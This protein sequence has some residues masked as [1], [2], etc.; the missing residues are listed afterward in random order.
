MSTSLPYGG[1]CLD[2]GSLGAPQLLVTGRSNE[3][4]H[5]PEKLGTS[6]NPFTLPK[7]PGK[8]K[9]SCMAVPYV[10]RVGLLCYVGEE[11][12]LR[13]KSLRLAVLSQA[14]RLEAALVWTCLG[15][16]INV[17]QQRPLECS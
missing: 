17:G 16:H 1:S 9:R 2:W 12:F 15:P 4:Q 13:K 14:D 6:P 7:V 5:A 3:L 10:A 11:W 8:A